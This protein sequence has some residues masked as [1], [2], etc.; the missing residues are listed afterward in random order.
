MDDKS[1]E[2][3]I[4]L[5]GHVPKTSGEVR[6]LLG[7]IGYHRRQIQDF[8]TLAHTLM[9]LLKTGAKD[10][11]EKNTS[12]RP[13]S[14]LS[15]HQTAL[16]QLNDAISLQPILA[17]PDYNEVFCTHRCEWAWVGVHSVPDPE[18]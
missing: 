10:P 1:V 9:E 12:K 3:V 13:V 7:L 18:W 8:A 2:V 11:G 15:E 4:A 17:Y 6:Q 5:K 14:W 16:D